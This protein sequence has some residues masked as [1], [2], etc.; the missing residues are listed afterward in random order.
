[1]PTEITNPLQPPN[2]YVNTRMFLDDG[3]R[4]GTLRLGL[5]RV[6]TFD[7]VDATRYLVREKDRGRLDALA[8]KYYGDPSLWWVI[9]WVNNIK[10]QLS[11]LSN[12][13][14]ILIP[15]YNEVSKQL[16]LAR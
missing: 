5:F 7:L 12:G 16:G 4:P 1:M 11:D 9:A 3:V 6:P 15:A 13:D 2:R 10:N 8:Y 14:V